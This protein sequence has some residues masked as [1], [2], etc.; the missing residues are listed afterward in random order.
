MKT[1]LLIIIAFISGLTNNQSF[2]QRHPIYDL[3]QK[4]MKG[5]KS[6]LFDIAKY[7][8]SKNEVTEFLG[9]HI[10]HTNESLVAKRIVEENC[11]FTDSEIT[12]AGN[13][14]SNDFLSFLNAYKDKI[15]FSKLWS[16][17]CPNYIT[18][19][20][21]CPSIQFGSSPVVRQPTI[22]PGSLSQNGKQHY[23]NLQ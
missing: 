3:E 18:F 9:Y 20:L 21:R 22:V 11:I 1:L 17:S 14:T 12:I 23:H 10:I 5:D 13:T 8:D 15:T 16:P 7:F 6:A 19:D 2:G 4:L